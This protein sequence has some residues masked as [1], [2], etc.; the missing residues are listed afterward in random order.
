MTAMRNEN[1]GPNAAR[2]SGERKMGTQ[3]DSA[4]TD[5]QLNR[6][7]FRKT[8]RRLYLRRAASQLSG[9]TLDF[10]CGVGELLACLPAGS[11]GLEYNKA[12]VQVCVANGLDVEFYDGTA[13]DW[14]LSPVTSRDGLS[15]MVI[16]H[17]LE[18][19]DEPMEI[20]RK[21]LHAAGEI[22][23]RHVLV[24]VPGKA[25][26]RSDPTHRT[27][28]DERMLRGAIPGHWRVRHSFHFPF[29]IK[30]VGDIFLY[31]ELH[32]LIDLVD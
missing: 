7:A 1:A 24:I 12:T 26:Y 13:D 25:G 18:H 4:Y 3:F 21:L 20:L 15:S 27:F 11:K 31:N 29:N 23:V 17:V 6:S 8:V 9:A 10:G 5:Y 28:V 19:L 30:R 16:S 22:G 32:L 2:T 14:S